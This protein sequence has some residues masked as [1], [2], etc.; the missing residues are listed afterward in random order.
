MVVALVMTI[1]AALA[2]EQVHIPIPWMLGPLISMA[3]VNLLGA[4]LEPIPYGRQ[5]GQ[6]FIGTG[7]GLYFT[8]SVLAALVSQ[9]W[10]I[11]LG[12]ILV[13]AVA[14]VGGR[15]LARVS[16]IDRTTCFFAT[17]P[18]GAAEMAV[19]AAR[20]GGMVPAVAIAQ[21]IRVVML[22][23]IVPAV[24]TYSGV[25][26]GAREPPLAL[27]FALQPFAI[28][29]AVSIV[30]GYVF[31]KLKLQNPWMMGPLLVT[32]ALACFETGQSAIPR[33]ISNL[34]QLML[35]MA[36]GSRFEREFF[37]R[38]RLFIPIALLN[39]SYIIVASAAV[40]LVVTWLA[41]IPLA[42][43]L[44]GCGPGGIAE[45]TITAKAL[46]LGVATVTAF[47]LVRI[48]LANFGAVYVLRLAVGNVKPVVSG[49]KF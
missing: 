10:V 45:M 21:S 1:A 11:F 16:G 19:L 29:I 17:V 47:Q 33:L 31:Q 28:M 13:M 3:V 15:L 30:A 5:T 44:T 18:G 32:A 34:S 4:A 9:A 7:V 46:S 39:G 24:V 26:A 35:G 25:A 48:V 12:G 8:P 37:L 40:A 27:P 2:F 22:V 41:G 43:A 20:Y 23:I 42:T 14:A 6:V 38:Y 49:P 36:L